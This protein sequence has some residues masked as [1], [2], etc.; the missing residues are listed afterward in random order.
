[1]QTTAEPTAVDASEPN[2]FVYLSPHTLS[3]DVLETLALASKPVGRISDCLRNWLGENVRAEQA[4]RVMIGD[5]SEP[6]EYFEPPAWMF[7]WHKLTD[8]ELAGALACSTSWLGIRL[9][10][11]DRQAFEA[12]HLAVV[13]AC[14]SRLTELQVAI[15]AAEQKRAK[16][17]ADA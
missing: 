5:W 6:S 1:M 9:S 14:C 17:F 2:I 15:D 8:G 4:R 7:P 10:D 13:T 11:A 16:D 3:T 12:I